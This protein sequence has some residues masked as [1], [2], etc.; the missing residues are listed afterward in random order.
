MCW[1]WK[2]II[3]YCKRDKEIISASKRS[4][5]CIYH[6]C[7]KEIGIR[8]I[9]GNRR[10][11]KL[12]SAK[13]KEIVENYK[14]TFIR[15]G[16][17]GGLYFNILKI[18]LEE[19]A[20]HEKQR[21]EAYK[22][23]FPLEIIVRHRIQYKM[24]PYELVTITFAA[25]FLECLIWDYAAVNTTQKMAK[26]YLGKMSLIGKWEVIP[27]LVNNDKKI[28]IGRKAI[29]LL[30]KL[31]TERNKIVHSNSKAL[32]DNYDEVMKY[33]SSHSTGARDITA[34]EAHQCVIG[35]TEGLK[36]IDTT[37]YWF[38]KIWDSY[39]KYKPHNPF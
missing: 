12:T 13:K 8:I 15:P 35:C 17:N 33:V 4:S 9:C 7:K 3:T 20:K 14:K 30:K 26:D 19:Y 38:F 6:R 11:P 39:D 31:V 24:Q 10:M 25:M 27:K 34:K 2:H 5:T 16:F 18:N 28:K 1:N 29:S 36:K 22:K 37:N 21:E 32:S 23:G